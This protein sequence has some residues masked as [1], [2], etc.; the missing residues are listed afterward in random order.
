V[1][2]ANLVL[3]ASREGRRGGKEPTG[4]PESLAGRRLPKMGDRAA[5]TGPNDLDELKKR[6]PQCALAAFACPDVH[7]QHVGLLCVGM[8]KGSAWRGARCRGEAA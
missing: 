7:C 5:T 1:Q 8:C 2:N 6:K 4:E 3:T